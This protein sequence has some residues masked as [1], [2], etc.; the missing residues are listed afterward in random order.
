[1]SGNWSPRR[2]GA[3]PGLGRDGYR[4]LMARLPTGVTVATTIDQGG[5]PHGMTASAVASASLDPPLV[6]VCVDREADFHA[7][8]LGARGFALSVLASDQER[9][10]RRFAD[11]RPD[12]FDG[13]AFWPGP[14]G[15]PLLDGAAAHVICDSRG[16]HDAGD[17][18]VFFGL[19]TAGT[20]FDRLP[21][22]HYRGGYTTIRGA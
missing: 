6:L 12:R 20:T 19:V 4:E 17:H 21:L 8:V 7:A 9:L 16:A 1:M 2:E 18:T 10:S 15:L 22:V 13:V 3:G 5:R 14:G 11:D